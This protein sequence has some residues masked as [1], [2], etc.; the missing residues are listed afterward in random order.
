MLLRSTAVVLPP[1]C[2]RLWII[3]ICTFMSNTSNSSSRWYRQDSPATLNN[4]SP[5]KITTGE[6]REHRGHLTQSS[7]RAQERLRPF[8]D[9]ELALVPVIE[10]LRNE[11]LQLTRHEHRLK[12]KDQELDREI[13][14]TSNRMEKRIIQR[15]DL[16][17][18][19]DELAVSQ[20]F[21]SM[22]DSLSEAEIIRDMEAL[23]EEIFQLAAIAADKIHLHEQRYLTDEESAKYRE[24]IDDILSPEFM[25]LV[26]SKKLQDTLAIQMG[27]QAILTRSCSGIIRKWDF[28]NGGEGIRRMYRHIRSQ[29]K[30]YYDLKLI[31]LICSCFFR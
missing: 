13:A 18:I 6:N 19:T 8:K 17:K 30:A 12:E 14:E 23:N 2:E 7:Q 20:R 15:A 5:E 10:E 3:L 29:S 1:V 31:H 21:L 16:K 26:V 28:K 24:R 11:I 4:C 22:A 25:E 27:W 9:S